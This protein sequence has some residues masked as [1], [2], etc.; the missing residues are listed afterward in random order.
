MRRSAG[1]L[2]TLIVLASPALVASLGSPSTVGLRP[3]P[4]DGYRVVYRVEDR[5]RREPRVTTEVLEVGRPYGARLEMRSGRPPGGE[6]T[7]GQVTNRDYFWQLGK[8]GVPQ[9]GVRRIPAGPA[10]DASYPA[11]L[12]A[13]HAGA[14]D[15][16]GMGRVLGRRC[17]WF[18]YGE[19]GPQRLRL[20]TRSSRIETCVDPSGIVLSEVWLLEGHAARVFEAV[21][22]STKAPARRRFLSGTDPA[23]EA[24]RR[25]DALRLIQGQFVVDDDADVDLPTTIS[26]PRGWARD[27]R[28]L[29]STASG[30]GR[31]TQFLSETFVRDGELV[32][33]ERGTHPAL[34]PGWPVSEGKRVELGRLGAGRIVYF[35]DR[36][37]LRLIGNVGFIRVTAPSQHLAV[38]FVRGLR[39]R[40]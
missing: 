32:V 19:P 13:V 1:L 3:E 40:Q 2:V 21:S 38:A 35:A 30:A 12:D 29:A 31:A 22:V 27:R 17:T 28:A 36:V 24:V 14:A 6:V 23:A 16:V 20:P 33:V 8:E 10:R 9:F 4:S 39:D 18:A 11:L 25:P 7:S 5:S 37:E 34:R 26:P 15:A